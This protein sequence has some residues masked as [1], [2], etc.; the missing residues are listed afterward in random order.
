MLPRLFK[1]FLKCWGWWVSLAAP[2]PRAWL[3]ARLGNVALD[4]QVLLALCALPAAQNIPEPIAPEQIA[5]TPKLAPILALGD[6]QADL[7]CPVTVLSCHQPLPVSLGIQCV[8][9]SR[10]G[11]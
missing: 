6:V 1:G 4:F 3:A 8:I 7:A 10:F 2:S 9:V 5:P 11:V